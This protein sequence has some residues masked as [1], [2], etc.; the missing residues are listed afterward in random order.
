MASSTPVAGVTVHAATPGP[1][2][3]MPDLLEQFFNQ[4]K[5]LLGCP[6]GATCNT[7]DDALAAKFIE[8]HKGHEKKCPT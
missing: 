6:C 2:A 1:I 5:H 7:T 4:K 8:A 3:A